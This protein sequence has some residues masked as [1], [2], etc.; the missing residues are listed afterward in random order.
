MFKP[1]DY[2]YGYCF[3]Q[4]WRVIEIVTNQG[5][6]KQNVLH[7]HVPGGRGATPQTPPH[8]GALAEHP[9]AGFEH[10]P[11]DG[12]ARAGTGQL[13]TAQSEHLR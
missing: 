1:Q 5:Q 13:G 12:Q 11:E 6:A 9:T 4:G 7:T 3:K 10:P 2:F 8:T